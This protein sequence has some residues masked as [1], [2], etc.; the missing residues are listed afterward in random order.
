[1][2]T[3]EGCKEGDQEGREEKEALTLQSTNRRGRASVPFAFWCKDIRRGVS[4]LP[5]RVFRSFRGRTSA[6]APRL[7][8]F[9]DAG[10][11]TY[12]HG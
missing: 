12:A 7:D 11:R 10:P 5:V 8:S 6:A 9:V 4:R 3:K 2:A 1:M